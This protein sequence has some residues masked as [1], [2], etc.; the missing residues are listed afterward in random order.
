MDV[1]AELTS[2]I[3]ADAVLTAPS[4]LDAVTEDWRGRYRG[5]ALCLARPANAGQVADVV[6]C[7]ARHGV[8]VLPQGGNTSLCGGAVPSETGPAPVILSL[9]RM[10]AVRAIDPVNNTMEVEAGCVLATVQEAAAAAAVRPGV[11]VDVTREPV[12][13]IGLVTPWNFPVATP[14]WKIAPALAFGNAVI[15]KPSEKTPGISIAVTRLIAEALEA[16]GMPSSLFNLVIGAGPNVGAAVVDTVDAVSFTGSVNTGRRI[17]VRCAERM[18]RVQLE[19]GG[20]NPLVVLGD[21]DPERA[22]EIG[23]NSAYFHAGQRCT[24]TG[25]FIVEDSIHDAFVAAMTERMAALRVGHALLPETQ[26]GPVIDEFQLTK[27]LQYIDTGLKEGA[28]LA[29]GGGRLDRPTRGWFLAPTLFT[30]TSNAM[31]INREEVFGPVASVIR[32]K[33]YEEA[34]AVANDTDYG[35]SS[36]IITNSMKHAR[37]FQANIQAGMTMLNLPTAGVDYHVPFG[38]RK[39]SSYGPREQGRS[40]IEFYTIIKTAYRAL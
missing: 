10:R 37:H 12:G 22:A 19:L 38:G 15:W 7:C 17:A 3:G 13:V 39:M 36:G 28:Q 34:L 33:D 40:A 6:R 14:M 8:P 9:T 27:N 31:T 26:I 16:H 4:D 5:P 1:I 32:V 24:A 2:L 35:L 21:A 29:S 30:E 25:R 18:I 11:E 20:Q 23:V